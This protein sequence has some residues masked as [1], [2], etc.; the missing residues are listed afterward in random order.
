VANRR[1][2]ATTGEIPAEQLVLERTHLRPL[3]LSALPLPIVQRRTS[4]VPTPIESL[5]HPLSMYE[6][7]LRVAS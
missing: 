4:R 2:H 1:L 6:Q 3:P 5:Q 7:L